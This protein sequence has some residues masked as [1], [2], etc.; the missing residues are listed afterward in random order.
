MDFNLIMVPLT[1]GIWEP[2][3][4]G[5]IIGHQ[6][7]FGDR[8]VSSQ[9]S[10]QKISGKRISYRFWW[11]D[12]EQKFTSQVGH[13]FQS[14]A[15]SR[16]RFMGAPCPHRLSELRRQCLWP[17]PL[18]G[19]CCIGGAAIGGV[20]DRDADAILTLILF[21]QFAT[22]QSNLL[23]TIA[24]IDHF[25][26]WYGIRSQTFFFITTIN[27]NEPDVN[28]FA[29]PY[30]YQRYWLYV[31]LAGV[32][33]LKKTPQR[34][35]S[36]QRWWKELWGQRPSEWCSKWRDLETKIGAL[37]L[38]MGYEFMWIQYFLDLYGFGN[39]PNINWIQKNGKK[40]TAGWQTRRSTQHSRWIGTGDTPPEA[41]PMSTPIGH[42]RPTMSTVHL[43]TTKKKHQ[44]TWA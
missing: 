8:L 37:E 38:D 19:H 36:F 2:T 22:N 16:R 44:R 11:E 33:G 17:L 23:I 32:I 31:A 43:S 25:Y 4:H 12:H 18:S 35:P 42:L 10:F 6:L 7:L 27:Q 34:M 40:G 5:F 9:V 20:G 15:F 3:S 14:P 28:H 41:A 29:S 26:A 13:I 39:H 1:G 30:V 21:R 24:N